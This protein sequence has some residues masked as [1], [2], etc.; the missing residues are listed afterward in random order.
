[1]FAFVSRSVNAFVAGIALN[2]KS[3]AGRGRTTLSRGPTVA[4]KRRPLMGAQRHGTLTVVTEMEVWGPDRRQL[5]TLGLS[6]GLKP[7]FG[8]FVK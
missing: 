3:G 7:H 6:V 4:L 8:K 5:F 1:M 2:G